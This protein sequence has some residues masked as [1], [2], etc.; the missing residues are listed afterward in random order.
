MT[1]FLSPDD[2][3]D[4]T[5]FVRVAEQDMWLSAQ[6]IPHRR[7]GRRM[8]VARVHCRAWLEGRQVIGFSEPNLEALL[9]A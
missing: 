6:G 1:E 3:F 9:G 4:L 7:D 2:L 8:I 5:G